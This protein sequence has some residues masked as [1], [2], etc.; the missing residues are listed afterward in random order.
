MTW[1]TYLKRDPVPWLLDPVNPPARLLTL[2][3]I[4]G[5]TEQSLGTEVALVRAWSP[6]QTLISRA[7]SQNFWGRAENPFFGGPLGTFGTLNALAQMAVP[8]F[9]VAKHACESL[10]AQ[11]RHIDGHIAP[12]DG[13]P[14]GR[15]AATGMALRL[16]WHFGYG[17]DARTQSARAA[18]RQTILH[19]FEGMRH[20]GVAG[21]EMIA[22]LLKALDGLLAIPE[23]LREAE[24]EQALQ[25]LAE[26]IVAHRFD[27]E[28]RDAGWLAF[29]FPRYH[30]SDLL[31]FCHVLARAGKTNHPY[32]QEYLQRIVSEQ[33]AE[34][35][36]LKA[37]LS[38]CTIQVERSRFP[39][40]WLTFAAVHTL[41]LTYGGNTYAT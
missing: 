2:R 35:R 39:S 7:D 11:G 10:L 16:L 33:T 6:L 1:L 19:H 31:E 29:R 23:S 27:F 38:P 15:L 41:I 14:G 17:E 28:G 34:G 32:F 21:S 4:F 22:C 25:F 36:W 30:D 13:P 18:L 9:P 12:E 5:R 8:A 3:D 40:R 37:Q 24:D 20:S 26:S